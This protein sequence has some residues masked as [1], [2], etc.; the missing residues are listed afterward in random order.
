LIDRRGAILAIS[1]LVVGCLPGPRPTADQVLPPLSDSRS[2]VAEATPHV[3]GSS[4]SDTTDAAPLVVTADGLTMT[5]R[6]PAPTVA[7]GGH[8]GIEVKVENARGT[9]V[10]HT[11]QCDAPVT[12]SAELPVPLAPAGRAWDGI[13]G[14]F[15]GY[16]L[17]QGMAPGAVPA[18]TPITVHARAFPCDG[19]DGEAF[20]EPGG[21]IQETLSLPTDLVE[22]VPAAPG[23]YELE[24]LF[25]YDRQPL[26]GGLVKYE[27]LR[28]T[29]PFK[30]EGPIPAVLSGAQAIDSILAEPRFAAWLARMPS[31]TWTN[32]NLF[33]EHGDGQGNVVP[34]GTTWSVELFRENGVPRNW[35]IGHVDPFTG[36]VRNLT[37]C[38]NPCDR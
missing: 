11:V 30:V 3:A 23:S 8:V 36:A 7:V 10:E 34:K 25:L 21:V 9:P 4:D 22:G 19:F 35:A 15:K 37:I 24:A 29:S 28:V 6:V 38:D 1:A 31:S 26:A 33:L 18:D 17:I 32:A 20:L 5:V 13:A 27:Q 14:T 12:A 16:V 2:P